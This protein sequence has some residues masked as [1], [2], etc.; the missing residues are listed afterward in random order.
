M[1]FGCSLLSEYSPTHQWTADKL[2]ERCMAMD[3]KNIEN[4]RK[5]NCWIRWT[6]IDNY[7]APNDQ[8]RY[9][10]FRMHQLLNNKN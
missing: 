9:V 3:A 8:T 1:F 6:M 7:V 5:L 4:Y 2:F 10:Y